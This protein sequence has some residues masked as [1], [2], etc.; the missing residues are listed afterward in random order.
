MSGRTKTSPK[1]VDIKLNYIYAI[2][3]NIINLDK[4]TKDNSSIALEANEIAK[5]TS[6]ISLT[7][8]Q[9][10]KDKDFLKKTIL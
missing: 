3:E 8:V 4:T 5:K 6:S 1:R 7:I 2:N 9:E 10:A